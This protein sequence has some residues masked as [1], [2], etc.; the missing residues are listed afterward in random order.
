MDSDIWGGGR[1]AELGRLAEVLWAPLPSTFDTDLRRPCET[2][3][4]GTLLGR[5]RLDPLDPSVTSGVPVDVL[6]ECVDDRYLALRDVITQRALRAA[7]FPEEAF[8]PLVARLNSFHEGSWDGPWQLYGLVGSDVVLADVRLD[9]VVPDVMAEQVGGSF[10]VVPLVGQGWGHPA[11]GLEGL[12]APPSVFGLVLGNEGYMKDDAQNRV[13]ELRMFV[14]V[15]A[16]GRWW[17]QSF[18]RHDSPFKPLR[19]STLGG[20]PFPPIDGDGH[21]TSESGRSLSGRVPETLG[22][23]LQVAFEP[24]VDPRETLLRWMAYVTARQAEE[25]GDICEVARMDPAVVGLVTATAMF[26][27]DFCSFDEVDTPRLGAAMSEAVDQMMEAAR[28]GDGDW[29]DRQLVDAVSVSMAV[30]VCAAVYRAQHGLSDAAAAWFGSELLAGRLA[31]DIG[32]VR[33]S[34]EH[35]ARYDTALAARVGAVID[36]RR[37]VWGVEEAVEDR[38]T[39]SVP[40]ASAPSVR[41]N[42]PCPCQSGRKHKHCCGRPNG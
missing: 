40:S 29:L 23:V 32:P 21:E 4:G 22:R 2:F 34:L 14:V 27:D 39:V 42:G 26:A 19:S 3:P 24:A 25:G 12:I 16:D 38:V 37:E 5:F 36:W 41:R 11:D 17:T 35:A 13:G 7:M 6:D 30:H 33:Q 31:W 1:D 9:Q 10:G 28:D 18:I 15:L 8:G 20:L